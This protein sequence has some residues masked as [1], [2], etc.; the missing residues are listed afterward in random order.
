VSLVDLLPPNDNDLESEIGHHQTEENNNEE[1]MPSA[2]R[3]VL[4]DK[5]TNGS[6]AT[7]AALEQPAPGLGINLNVTQRLEKVDE[8][9]EHENEDMLAG[10]SPSSITPVSK[11]RGPRKQM[12]RRVPS[13]PQIQKKVEMKP[14]PLALSKR[15][16]TTPGGG[17]RA[18]PEPEP[19]PEDLGKRPE[20]FIDE[21]LEGLY[22]DQAGSL[23]KPSKSH[24]V[25]AVEEESPNTEQTPPKRR[26]GQVAL[27]SVPV[28]LTPTRRSSNGNSNNNSNNILSPSYSS[29]GFAPSPVRTDPFRPSPLR[30][31]RKPVETSKNT[32]QTVDFFEPTSYKSFA[33]L[34]SKEGPP[35][36]EATPYAYAHRIYSKPET[37]EPAVVRFQHQRS[38]TVPRPALYFFDDERKSIQQSVLAK[39]IVCKAHLNCVECV[40]KEYSYLEIKTMPTT[41]PPEERAKILAGNRSLR[42]IKTVRYPLVHL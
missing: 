28:V 10:S 9:L 40:E 42:T 31:A 13:S 35:P 20:H 29:T 32:T 2:K 37:V 39:K 16:P 14:P 3:D 24:V 26:Q 30:S 33:I 34:P 1:E 21:L 12:G 17:K 41:M 7:T 4:G 15:P 22:R 25:V 36:V 23:T 27:P 5:S 6:H 38:H 8:W 18:Y 19:K 11:V